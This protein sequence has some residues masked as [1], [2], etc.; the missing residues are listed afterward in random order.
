MDKHEQFDI[1]KNRTNFE[2]KIEEL[3]SYIV[4]FFE[5]DVMKLKVYPSN[6]IV[7]DKNQQPIILITYDEYSF[8]TNDRIQKA[9]TQER[10]TFL[11]LKRQR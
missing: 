7:K 9:W 2:K 10:N 11:Y 6:C 3:K 1:V 4:K 5:D 8:S